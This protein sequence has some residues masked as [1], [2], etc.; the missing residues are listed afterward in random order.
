MKTVFLLRHAKSSWNQPSLDD[1]KRP[2]SPRGRRA[3]SRMGRHLADEGLIPHRVLCSGAVRAV[4][5][6]EIV[7]RALGGKVPVEFRDEI[8]HASPDTLIA[9]IR[10][11]PDA[12]PSVLLV[13]HNPTFESVA[14][15]L[16][17]SGDGKALLDMGS[18]FPTGALAILDFGI[19]RWT[20]ME[21]GEGHLRDFIRPRELD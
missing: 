20:E 14:L 18:K 5:T 15:S 2:L 10:S 7:S 1:F 9:L 13:G 11:L 6:W 12:W 4:E 21:E 3:A 19:G 16:A 8:Y 17:G